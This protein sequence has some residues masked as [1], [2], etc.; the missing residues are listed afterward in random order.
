[1]PSDDLRPLASSCVGAL[2]ARGVERE[3]RFQRSA[4][5]KTPRRPVSRPR[6]RRRYAVRSP[7]DSR[8]FC[9]RRRQAGRR[10]RA[11]SY[12]PR[13]VRAVVPPGCRPRGRRRRGVSRAEEVPGYGRAPRTRDRDT[14]HGARAPR[15]LA[16]RRETTRGPSPA[17]PRGAPSNP[18]A[19]GPP[20]STRVRSF[21][22][23]RHALA[24][25]VEVVR[26][27]AQPFEHGVVGNRG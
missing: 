14:S 12:R 8:G 1:V 5:T 18:R 15:R 21:R 25:R 24:V 13:L 26:G 10:C 20:L 19:G 9:R 3:R 7:C 27:E 2:L 4:R 22:R 23:S 6:T 11:G 16:E 17:T